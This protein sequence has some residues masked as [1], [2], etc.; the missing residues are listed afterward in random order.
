MVI[1]WA[2]RDGDEMQ[3]R[4]ERRWID[5]VVLREARVLTV[6]LMRR[7][8]WEGVSLTD[9]QRRGSRFRVTRSFDSHSMIGNAVDPS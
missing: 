3:G 1:L 8:V 9:F 2:E 7:R 4:E 5:D 6:T